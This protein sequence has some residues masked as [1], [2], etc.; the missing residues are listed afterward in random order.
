M[1]SLRPSMRLALSVC[2]LALVVC[3]FAARP[4]PAQGSRSAGL[5]VSDNVTASDIGLPVYPGAKPYRDPGGKDSNAAR[6]TAWAGTWGL[7]V[8]ATKLES[9]DYPVKVA[10]FY[11]KALGKYG[12]VLDCANGGRQRDDDQDALT[13][14]DDKPDPGGMLFKVGTKA[15]QHLVA[16]NPHGR[17]SIFSLIY[18]RVPE[19]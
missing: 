1:S 17:G 19:D 8:A 14:G 10:E 6:I 12:S 18:L 5:I 3:A 13:C 9:N 4:L 11:R 15:E 2:M 7:K 16:I